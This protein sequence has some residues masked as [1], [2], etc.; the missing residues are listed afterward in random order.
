[1]QKIE[2]P[3]FPKYY[4]CENGEIWSEKTKRFLKKNITKEGYFRVGLTL[5]LETRQHLVHRLI[6]L[7]FIPNPE[8]YPIVNHKD[9]NKQNNVPSNLE[10]CTI[11]Y[12]S[13]YG[14]GKKKPVV[15]CD[16]ETHQELKIFNSAQE[17][18]DFLQKPSAKVISACASG[19]RKSAY[20]YWWKYLTE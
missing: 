6:A 18:V 7:A 12:N 17:A 4:A 5:G 2:I 13:S 10:W 15:M 19:A 16:K 1:M 8:N 14:Q 20:N 3:G 9:E 11:S